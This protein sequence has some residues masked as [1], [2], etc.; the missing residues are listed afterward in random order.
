VA[1]VRKYEELLKQHNIDF[2]PL[3]S[4]LPEEAPHTEDHGDTDPEDSPAAKVD[5]SSP[6]ASS[7]TG[8]T[9]EAK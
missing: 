9:Y 6:S 2:E 7:Q 4:Q 1:R 8:K 3:H 5:V